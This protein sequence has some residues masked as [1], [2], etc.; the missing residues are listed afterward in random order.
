MSE[1]SE[2]SVIPRADAYS[3]F[4]ALGIEVSS[5]SS[6]EFKR[7]YY[8]LALEHQ[9]RTSSHDLMAHINLARA[10]IIR[11]HRWP[12][13]DGG[14]AAPTSSPPP[15]AHV[16]DAAPAQQETHAGTL[17]S[18]CPAEDEYQITRALVDRI[19]EQR[20]SAQLSLLG[21]LQRK[22]Q[23]LFSRDPPSR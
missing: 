7:T 16:Q 12:K 10:S 15:E 6:A 22:L 23:R 5:M 9:N 19:I 2:A 14:S 21:R 4:R 11:L 18:T 1:R 20:K 3:V 17:R 13:D 8:G